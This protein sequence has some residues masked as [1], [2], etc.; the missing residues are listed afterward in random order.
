VSRR[1]RV[2]LAAGALLAALLALR[3]LGLVVPT[4]AED[5]V[6]PT[7]ALL[8]V[9]A[10]AALDG[11]ALGMS[12]RALRHARPVEPAPY[13][14]LVESVGDA[15]VRYRFGRVGSLGTL[16][17]D[18]SGAVPPWLRLESVD[19]WVERP[20]TAA[21]DSLWA[22]VARRLAASA[23]GVVRC[24]AYRHG[25]T[26]AV[27]AVH[28]TDGRAIV[29]ARYPRREERDVDGPFVLPASVLAVVARDVALVVPESAARTPIACPA[30]R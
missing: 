28:E 2:V 4:R 11:V 15:R 19:A 9:P 26:P 22:D 20:S 18:D 17:M 14:G 6:S 1:G 23:P 5:R 3:L 8:G 24:F 29:V 25:I 12:P 30:T 13:V 7:G 10:L 16:W 21:A 27:A